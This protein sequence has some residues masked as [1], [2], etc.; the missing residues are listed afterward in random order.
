MGDGLEEGED[1]R[2]NHR[3]PPANAPPRQEVAS[4]TIER[5]GN[6]GGETDSQLLAVRRRNTE[7]ESEGNHAH[8][9]HD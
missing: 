4:G 9:D 5:S 6:E 7:R 8:K 3:Y 2:C 1:T